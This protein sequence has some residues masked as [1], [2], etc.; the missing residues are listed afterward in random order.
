MS[1][2][3]AWDIHIADPNE[4]MPLPLKNPLVPGSRGFDITRQS[5]YHHDLSDLT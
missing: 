3:G 5:C 4:N 2:R 1:W